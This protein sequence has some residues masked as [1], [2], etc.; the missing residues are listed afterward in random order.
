MAKLWISPCKGC[1]VELYEQPNFQ[2]RRIR[3]YGPADFV[4]LWVGPD[5]GSEQ[6][7]SLVAGPCAWVL[8]FEEFNI[9]ESAVWLAP[10]QRVADVTTLPTDEDLDSVRLFDRPPFSSEPG[11][12]AYAKIHGQPPETIKLPKRLPRK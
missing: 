11:F 2:G 9:R 6:A 4:N 1:W 8:C 5:D 10:N 12:E 3:L 7:N